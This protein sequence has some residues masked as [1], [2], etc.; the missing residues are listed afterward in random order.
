[1]TLL[2]KNNAVS[3]LNGSIA[4]TDTVISI[5]SGDVSLFPVPQTG[6]SFLL[7]IEDRSQSPFLREIVECTGVS[8]N[9]FT[10]V[11]GQEDTT[12]QAF[13]SGVYVANRL[14]AGTLTDLISAAN[15]TAPVYIGAYTEAPTTMPNGTTLIIGSLYYNITLTELFEWSV[16]SE[17]VLVSG[18]GSGGGTNVGLYLGSFAS[19]PLEQPNGSAIVLGCMYYDTTLDGLYI[20]ETNWTIVTNV[21]VIPGNVSIGGNLTVAGNLIVG[22]TLT[23]AG[24][25]T[26]DNVSITGTLLLDGQPV[27]TANE[28]SGTANMQQFP[29]GTIIQWGISTYGVAV[30]FPQPYTTTCDYV[31]AQPVGETGANQ[32]VST[33]NSVTLT[34]FLPNFYFAGGGL[35]SFQCYWLASGK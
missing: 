9:L 17:W 30:D 1:M 29:D 3:T 34:G 12:P 22:G 16:A 4:A 27:V 11:R 33:V 28:L 14:T 2:F 20:F 8:G 24:Q 13:N 18:G 23:V 31:M 21:N 15:S 7:T 10:V 5:Q 19:A 26:F 25:A 32:G 35:G 6:E